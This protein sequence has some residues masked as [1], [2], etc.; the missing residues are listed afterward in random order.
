MTS[1]MHPDRSA[2]TLA[3]TLRVVIA[4]AFF[5]LLTACGGG[6]EDADHVPTPAVDCIAHPEQCR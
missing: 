6:D 1:Q 5:A 4:A 2:A 3:A